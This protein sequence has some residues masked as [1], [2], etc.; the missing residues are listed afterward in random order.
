MSKLVMHSWAL[1][2]I[3]HSYYIP[4]V[5]WVY[6]QEIRKRFEK[7]VL[8]AP[9]VAL[10]CEPDDLQKIEEIGTQVFVEEAPGKVGFSASMPYFFHYA[11]LLW[12]HRNCDVCYVRFP[13]PFS[14]L[15]SILNVGKKRIFHFVGDPVGTFGDLSSTSIKRKV[16]ARL[17]YVEERLA[18]HAAKRSS[19][20][21]I[22]GV[23]FKDRLDYYN[24][25]YKSVI[26]STLRSSDFVELDN[27]V[28]VEPVF[29]YL[30]YLRLAK[31][32]DTL[33]YAV[34]E[35]I[36][37]Y[38]QARLLIVGDGDQRANLMALTEHVGVQDNVSFY[39]HIDSRS[40]LREIT[41]KASFFWF[42]SL[43]EGSPR[44]VLEA[45][46]W[47]LPVLST[48]VGSLPFSFQDGCDLLFFPFR[49]HKSLAEITS[50]LLENKKEYFKIRNQS[51]QK[52]RSLTI[53]NLIEEIFCD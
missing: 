51:F 39:G 47:G 43:S 29:L 23:T 48:P 49:D 17:F 13:V 20:V 15:P 31:S 50:Y 18:I 52:I 11:R 25:Q 5:H 7:I 3:G 21:C 12:R 33:I 14:W 22:N 35:L 42:P 19:K 1:S 30:G 37:V 8:V 4:Y 46:S 32:V 10:D 34:R 36:D 16:L 53:E 44:S 40:Y 38:P 27:A 45:I 9:I 41:H 24:V 28:Q 6:L 2:K 26:S